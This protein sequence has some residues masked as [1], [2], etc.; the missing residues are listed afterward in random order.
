MN[1]YINVPVEV[2]KTFPTLWSTIYRDFSSFEKRMLILS[3]F[4]LLLSEK[5]LLARIFFLRSRQNWL[6]QI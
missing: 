6:K 1:K 3:Q 5:C 2:L 4:L